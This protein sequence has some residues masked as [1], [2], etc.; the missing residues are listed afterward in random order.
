MIC[1]GDRCSISKMKSQ[2]A[3]VCS[4]GLVVCSAMPSNSCF[5]RSGVLTEMFISMCLF[6]PLEL[7]LIPI[8]T[9]VFFAVHRIWPPC[10]HSPLF[11]YCWILYNTQISN[12]QL[13]C[14]ANHHRISHSTISL[15]K[16][17]ISK[18]LTDE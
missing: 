18:N 10:F 17:L 8:L 7:N 9:I 6:V 14:C 11:T 5:L 13:K 1:S 12:L 15:I 2:Q 4:D 16:E 3:S